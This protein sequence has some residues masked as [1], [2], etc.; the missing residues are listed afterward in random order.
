FREVADDLPSYGVRRIHAALISDPR[1]ADATVKTFDGNVS[2]VDAVT[3]RVLE[4]DPDIVGFSAYVWSMPSFVAI[5]KRL[6]EAMPDVTIIFGGP[7]A[8]P[9]MFAFEPYK[10]SVPAIELLVISHG[11]ETIRDIVL[12]QDR[13]PDAFAKIEG[14]AIPHETGWHKTPEREWAPLDTLASPAQLGLVP[15]GA[16]HYLETYRGCPMSCTFCQWGAAAAPKDVLS[17]AGIARELEAFAA[18]DAFGVVHLDAGLTLNERAFRNFADAEREVGFLRRSRLSC[19]VYPSHLKR[20][21]VEFLQSVG[22]SYI[23]VGLQSY[24]EQVLDN[25]ERTASP[26]KFD[27]IVKRLVSAVGN[28]AIEIILGLPGDSLESFKHT[29]ERA[30]ELGAD[31]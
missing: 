7:S 29:A 3:A 8:R 2:N 14:V 20:T 11:E 12:L 21:H 10:S 19:E 26:A 24:N 25:V 28:V 4:F 18:N 30:L 23:G 9:E 1:L 16:W 17:P 5:A 13:T 27:D 31:V 6:R 15:R 22:C